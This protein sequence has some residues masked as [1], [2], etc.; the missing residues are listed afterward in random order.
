M[1]PIPKHTFSYCLASRWAKFFPIFIFIWVVTGA[2]LPSK[3]FSQTASFTVQPVSGSFCVPAQVRFVPTFSQTPVAVN[4]QFGVSGAESVQQSPTYTYTST[5]TYRVVLSVLFDSSL[6]EVEQLVTIS[7]STPIIIQR[8]RDFI[9]SASEVLF[10][11][12]HSGTITST[13]WNFDDGSEPQVAPGATQSH[14]FSEFRNYTIRATATNQF[15]CISTAT[16][17]LP[18]R[19]PTASVSISPVNGCLPA[20]TT[21]R[22]NVSVPAGTA[23]SQYIWNFGD[24]SAI[25]TTNVNNVVHTY[26]NVSGGR[27]SVRVV[28]TEGCINT[29]TF[30]SVAFGNPPRS[31]R[32]IFSDSILCFSQAGQF[33]SFANNANQYIWNFRDGTTISTSDTIIQRRFSRRGNF[34]VRV[35]PL[36]NGCAGP[37]DSFFIRVVGPDAN[38]SFSNSCDS[39]NTFQFIDSTIGNVSFYNWRFLGAGG[40][41]SNQPNPQFTFPTNGSHP[42]RL[43]AFDSNTGCSDTAR[44]NIYTATPSLQWTD[45]FACR[46]SNVRIA[47]INTYTNPNV[48]YDFRIGGIASNNRTPPSLTLTMKANGIFSNR[49]VIRNGPGYCNDTLV[50]PL[51]LRVSGPTAGFSMPQFICLSDSLLPAD[52]SSAGFARDTLVRWQWSFNNG[53][54]TDSNRIPQPM[55]FGQPGTYPVRLQ[56]QDINGCTDSVVSPIL[57]RS[58]PFLLVTPPSS[59]LCAGTELTIN[60]VHQG[61]L[62]WQPLGAVSC[63]TCA[64]I[65]V[66]PQVPTTYIA[67]ATDTFGCRN[68]AQTAIDIFQPYPFNPQLA[69]T[70]VCAGQSV[71]LNSGLTG[72]LYNWSPATGLSATNVPNPVANTATTTTYTLNVIDSA[73]CF[74]NSAQVTVSIFPFPQVTM[75]QDVI[76]GYDEPFELAPQY[77][78]GI[79]TYRWSPPEGLNCVTCPAPSGRGRITTPY[80][81]RATT[82]EGC[83][84]EFSVNVSIRCTPGNILMPTAF[85]PNGDNLNDVYY[86]IARGV[87]EI[88]KFVVFNRA[89]EVVFERFNFRPNEKS[90]GWNGS[91]KGRPQP[92]GNYIYIV[93]ALCDLGEPLSAK[94]SVMLLR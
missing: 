70:G 50:Q 94:G 58:L 45:T 17:L 56:V 86:P 22:A 29:F 39:K 47:A 41:E 10:A 1:W 3:S 51:P 27:A 19:L 60:A 42:V 52:T 6:A 38:F 69:D 11:L 92:S 48:L 28:T 82:T 2:V 33:S 4:W 66:R 24:N 87:Q 13:I 26:T 71:P 21:L 61:S 57:V 40:P 7:T 46:N 34:W 15:G 31:Q 14:F 12:Q 54:Q 55:R 36:Q 89:G 81:L 88:K 72:L 23:V 59:I 63:D 80:V 35:T 77:G 84:Q 43:I 93:E 78:P 67:A 37:V 79:A 76:V 83:A 18:F 8:N 62:Q 65:T 16:T 64:T 9:C 75:P 91:F 49:I 74:P 90:F 68:T 30:D 20:R 32:V 73:G 85:T 44:T 5:G 53:M 25:R